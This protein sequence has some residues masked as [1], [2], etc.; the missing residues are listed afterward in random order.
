M[1]AK[2][3]KK[4]R[5]VTSINKIS[6]KQCRCKRAQSSH[7]LHI[8]VISTWTRT[9][10]PQLSQEGELIAI[11][12]VHSIFATETKVKHALSRKGRYQ[13]CI[14]D[15][16]AAAGIDTLLGTRHNIS[17]DIIITNVMPM[18]FIFLQPLDNF[19]VDRIRWNYSRHKIPLQ[20]QIKL[21][22]HKNT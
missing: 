18:N 3:E 16:V 22:N 6:L 10:Q 11:C 5:K 2:Y 9:E 21:S 15:V 19:S 4:K 1:S 7:C 12:P 8:P 17:D 14:A 13:P 20:E